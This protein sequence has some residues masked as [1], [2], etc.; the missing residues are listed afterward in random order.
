MRQI[1]NLV[2]RVFGTAGSNPALSASPQLPPLALEAVFQ[3]ALAL[4]CAAAIA[5]GCQVHRALDIATDP[6]GAEVRIDDKAVGTTPLLVPFE[7]YGT[8]RLTFYKQGY[9]TKSEVV[10]IRPAWY[11]HFPFDAVSEGLFGWAWDDVRR[12]EVSLVPETER[13]SQEDIEGLLE[14]AE[15]LRSA[16]PSGPREAK[17]RPSEADAE[18]DG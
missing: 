10:Q 16:G 9:L 2:S 18:A 11:A 6:P 12:F 8:R 7:H 3:R 15:V 1:A 17:P 13:L 5:P 14:R 4:A